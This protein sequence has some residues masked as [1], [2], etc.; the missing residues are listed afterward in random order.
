MKI[1]D[2]YQQNKIAGPILLWYASCIVQVLKRC[3]TDFYGIRTEL[4]WSW[5]VSIMNECA[6]FLLYSITRCKIFDGCKTLRTLWRRT[7]VWERRR[8]V[9]SSMTRHS[10]TYP[11]AD[12][13]M[14]Y[15]A[16]QYSWHGQ[17]RVSHIIVTYLWMNDMT[18][19]LYCQTNSTTRWWE[20]A[21]K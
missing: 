4:E 1:I 10:I 7:L 9:L 20:Y 6:I 13:S 16:S 18:N 14:E 3:Y 17:P 11:N 12:F 19:V 5:F 2:W 21:E 15:A 8:V